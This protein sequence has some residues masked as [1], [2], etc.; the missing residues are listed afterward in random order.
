MQQ[1][2]KP[3]L[4]IGKSDDIIGLELLL[5]LVRK[6]LI[7]HKGSICGLNPPD[8]IPGFPYL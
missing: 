8:K 5:L 6:H 2:Y 4:N 3:V 1:L 7:I